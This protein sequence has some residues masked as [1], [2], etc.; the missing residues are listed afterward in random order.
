[1]KKPIVFLHIPKTAGQ[2]IDK[3]LKEKISKDKYFYF[4]GKKVIKENLEIVKKGFTFC[5]VRDPWDR[6]VSNYFYSHKMYNLLEK[7]TD[8]S[9]HQLRVNI[10]E[11]TNSFEEYVYWIYKY[12][13]NTLNQLHFIPQ[14]EFIQPI[15]KHID[16]IGRYENLNKNIKKLSKVLK[17][18]IVLSIVNNS[19]ERKKDYISY[20]NKETKRM[21]EEMYKADIK[22]FKYK[23]GGKQE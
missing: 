16:F 9:I 20:Y 6:M 1:M 7:N 5:F 21:V 8:T 19:K 13:E 18:P 23:F 4:H 17:I 14:S 12:R 11:K 15:R 10:V 22:N 3:I 2:S